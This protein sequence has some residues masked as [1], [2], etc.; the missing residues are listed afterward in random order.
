MEAGKAIENANTE[1]KD[2]EDEDSADGKSSVCGGEM[3]LKYLSTFSG[4]GGFEL[5][6][7]SVI[8]EAECIGYSE[9]DSYA[10]KCYQQHFPSHINLGDITLIDISTLPY[11][12]L[13]VGGSPCQDLSVAKKDRQSLEGERSKL[14][15]N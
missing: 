14:S 5:G 10:I 13:L 2:G 11:F 9:I 3:D 8:P 6:I 4:I 15:E 7:Q 12:D 1:I